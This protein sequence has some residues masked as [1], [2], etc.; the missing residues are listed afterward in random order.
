MK[1]WCSGCCLHVGTAYRTSR[2][3]NHL[4]RVVL[5]FF[6]FFSFSSAFE[7]FMIFHS[8]V[9]SFPS[10]HTVIWSDLTENINWMWC[11]FFFRTNN[12][13]RIPHI[14]TRPEWMN[15]RIKTKAKQRNYSVFS[16]SYKC[17]YWSK[18]VVHLLFWCYFEPYIGDCLSSSDWA[19]TRKWFCEDSNQNPFW[20]N[21]H[22]QSMFLYKWSMVSQHVIERE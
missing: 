19:G 6:F 10:W 3:W 7:V 21:V 2:E 20:E 11:V 5:L 9:G 16:Q 14:H 12:N 18:I 13:N 8:V 17:G 15:K 1:H 22:K 4:D